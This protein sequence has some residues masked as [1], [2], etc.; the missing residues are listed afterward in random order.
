MV[1][2]IKK[3]RVLV[4]KATDFISVGPHGTRLSNI[5]IRNVFENVN[6]KDN[7]ILRVLKK[8]KSAVQTALLPIGYPSESAAPSERHTLRKPLSE[9]VTEL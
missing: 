6:A 5:S 9:T 1:E 7:G 3:E 4:P 2:G 8:E